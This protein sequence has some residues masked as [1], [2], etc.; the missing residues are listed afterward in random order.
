MYT[1]SG[2]VEP[3]P[4]AVR[5][6]L[7]VS[8]RTPIALCT[9][10][11]AW[12][13][14]YPAIRVMVETV[15]PLI[16]TAARFL[17]AGAILYGYLLVRGGRQRVRVER[18]ELAGA[19]LI[20]TIILGD[21]GLLAL[22]EQEVPAG[23]AAL[24]IASVPL[25]VVMLRLLHGEAVPAG[26]L[27]AVAAGFAGVALLVLP[28]APGG[29]S[30]L[31]WLLVLVLAA[32][33][34]AVGQFYSQRTPLPPDPL[35]TTALELLAAAGVLFVAGVAT[36]ELTE[37]RPELFSGDSVLAF[38]Y[39]I[40]PGS[41]LAYSAFVWLLEHAP[42]STVS[43]YA[44]VNPVVAVLLGWALLSEAIT[45]PLAAGAVVVLAS[46]AFIVRGTRP[47]AGPSAGRR[48][49]SR[50]RRARSGASPRRA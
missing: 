42:I 38:A 5:S 32:A 26:V 24:I 40:G 10:Y 33:V 22:A 1:R 20:G 13:A 7:L 27:A 43:T 37:L 46:V 11:L 29:G 25:W 12:G 41:L 44:Y 39:L 34:E 50:P 14:T 4:P 21:I 48:A 30:P 28:G 16:G 15:P 3:H 36:G 35:V 2:R 18:R 45:A 49:T 17:V 47:Q 9:V 8:W 19:A 31:G 23:L 6:R